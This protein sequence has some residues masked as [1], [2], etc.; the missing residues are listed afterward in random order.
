MAVD[1]PD[2]DQPSDRLPCGRDLADLYEHL[3]TGAL[4][5]HEQ[6]CPGCRQAADA[7]AP[8]LQAVMSL[9]AQKPEPPAGFVESVMARIRADIRRTRYLALAAESPST[10]TITE[11]AAAAIM[12]GAADTIPGVASRGCRFPTPHDPTHV[13]ISISLHY[14]L[15]AATTADQVRTTLRKAARTQL[16]IRLRQI[17]VSIDD[18]HTHGPDATGPVQNR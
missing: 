11:R 17:D 7:F 6:A 14:G 15:H 9:A 2:G 4:D 10:L 1:H 13:A 18:V 8:A 12:S 16:G 3:S 5:A